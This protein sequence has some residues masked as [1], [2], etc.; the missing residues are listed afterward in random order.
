MLSHTHHFYIRSSRC[1]RFIELNWFSLLPWQHQQVHLFIPHWEKP[2][3]VSSSQQ[4]RQVRVKDD[5]MKRKWHILLLD[6]SNFQLPRMKYDFTKW[7]KCRFWNRQAGEKVFFTSVLLQ[8][9]HLLKSFFLSTWQ[10]DKHSCQWDKDLKAA[11]AEW[12]AEC[13]WNHTSSYTAEKD[14]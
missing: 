6:G 7:K 3:L 8:N 4:L 10:W 9:I 5:L 12:N 14:K 11:V 1:R 13:N 2:V